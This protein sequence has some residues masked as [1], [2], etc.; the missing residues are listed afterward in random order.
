MVKPNTPDNDDQVEKTNVGEKKLTAEEILAQANI[1]LIDLQ[2]QK[3][4]NKRDLSQLSRT[5]H[6]MFEETKDAK[7]KAF[8]FKTIDA[9]KVFINKVLDAI[10]VFREKSHKKRKELYAEEARLAQ[11]EEETE[12]LADDKFE[13][14]KPKPTP[15]FDF[16]LNDKKQD[17]FVEQNSNQ[18]N[19]PIKE[20]LLTS[21]NTKSTNTKVERF[22]DPSET[23]EHLGNT[24]NRDASQLLKGSAWLTIGN[25]VSRMLGALYVIPWVAM[26]YPHG[27]AANTLFSQGYAIYALFLM[28]STAGIPA[29]ISKLVAQYNALGQGNVSKKLIRNSTIFSVFMGIFVGFLLYI[30][31]PVLD[32]GQESLARVLHALVPAVIV[33]PCLSM[34]RGYFQGHQM[35]D[36]SAKSQVIEQVVRILYMLISG[37]IVLKITPGDWVSVVVHSTFA[38]FIGALAAIIVLVYYGFKRKETFKSYIKDDEIDL[39]KISTTNLLIQILKESWPFVVIG[40]AITISQ[41]IDQYSFLNI[42][43]HFTNYSRQVILDDFGRFNA[44]ANKLIMIIVPLAVSIAET[45]LPMLSKT[46]VLVN[47]EQRRNQ[48]LMVYRLY[49]LAMIPASLGMFA[50]AKP[51]YVMF[52]GNSDPMI[53]RGVYLLQFSCLLAIIFGLFMLLSIILQAFN[54]YKVFLNAFWRFV[55]LKIVLQIPLVAFLQSL[56]ALLATFIAMLFAVM[57]MMH[58]IDIKYEVSYSDILKDMT[59]TVLIGFVMMIITMCFVSLIQIFV[60]TNRQMSAAFVSIIAAMF[61]A[62][63]VIVLYLR[64]GLL[65]YLLGSKVNRLPNWILKLANK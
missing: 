64:A 15:D 18:K 6:L 28:I 59:K 2:A 41:L 16:K 51:L 23:V 50:I 56:G 43:S 22:G 30:L 26:L 3:N 34:W 10:V 47:D 20:N 29:G 24:H 65:K 19:Y 4:K 38:A 21:E 33:F 27:L 63:I 39:K 35:M 44:N 32:Q 45:A 57:Y 25:F 14:A 31:T 8:F 1:E 17:V 49:I 48:L 12:K 46:N 36:V 9:I 5:Q 42:M 54:K 62:V 13:T 11:L 61:G 7:I 60:N 52:Y 37:Y 40:S 53:T 55:V 58:Y